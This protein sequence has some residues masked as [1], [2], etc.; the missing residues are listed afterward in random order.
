MKK[1]ICLS[2]VTVLIGMYSG[3]ANMTVLR[4]QELRMVQARVDSL[5]VELTQMQ[6]LIIEEQKAQSE[7]LRLIRA[8][9]QV[10]FN[11]ID[12]KVSTIDGNLNEN[13]ARLSKIDEKNAEFNKKIEAKFVADSLA[14]QSH[15]MEIDKLFQISMNDFNAGRYDVA[16][17]GFKDFFTQYPESPMAS[18]AEY[19]TAECMYAKRSYADAEKAYIS[20]IKKYPQGAKI[21][22]ALYKLGLVYNKQDKEKSKIMVWKKLVEQY[23]DS[24]EAQVV[25]AQ[26]KSH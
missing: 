14:A 17:S 18:E 2:I 8:D 20:Y 26:Q 19:W 7:L 25:K 1:I 4:T 24:Q 11:E 5:H 6:K 16:F 9:Q 10:R 23:P 15:S 12:R 3:C 13:H 22:V 21:S